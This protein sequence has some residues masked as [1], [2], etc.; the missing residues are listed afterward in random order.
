MRILD[1]DL[2]FFLNK[3]A[4]DKP[5]NNVRLDNTYIPWS[6]NEVREFMEN[7]LGLSKTKPIQG[8]V[9]L[10]HD[11]ALFFWKRL[12][13]EIKLKVPFDV[14][15]IDAH[16]DLGLGIS[17][18]YICDEILSEKVADRYSFAIASKE[19]NNDVALDCGN[20]LL[21]AIAC[22]WIKS[23]VFIPNPHTDVCNYISRVYEDR[24]NI[25][26]SNE[27]NVDEPRIPYTI[28]QDYF[29]DY[30]KDEYS[31]DYFVLS[32]SPSYTPKS[33]DRLI[34]VISEYI[35]EITL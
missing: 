5:C 4:L 17:T 23:L 8:K 20:Y 30:R 34:R 12:I 32:I 16:D 21:F 33:S 11:E 7:V 2:D 10:H 1:I 9:V 13:D 27:K 35:S 19:M 28:I 22:R 14:V 25:Y 3:V 26:L 31:F 6:E 24:C 15:H 29:K 18:N